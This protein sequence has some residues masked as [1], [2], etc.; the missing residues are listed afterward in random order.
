MGGGT[1]SQRSVNSEESELK[2]TG[3]A[4][5]PYQIGSAAALAE[6]RDKVNGGERDADAVLTANIDLSEE[7]GSWTPIGNAQ[8]VSGKTYKGSF[9]GQ[10]HSVKNLYIAGSETAGLFGYIGSSGTVQNLR[11]SGSITNTSNTTTGGGVAAIN[12]G[13]IENC[14]SSVTIIATATGN[15]AVTVGGVVGL[16]AIGSSVTNCCNSSSVSGTGSGSGPIVV[17]GVV[18][19][20]F[21]GSLTV[22][23]YATEGDKVTIEV[24]PD[25][26]YLLDELVVTAGGKDVELTDNHDGTFTFTM[27]SA[28]VK[29]TATFAED[30]DW[31]EPEEPVTDVSDIFLDVA[32]NAWYKDAVQYAYD[33]GLMTGVSDTE[34]APEATTTR[35]ET[36]SILARLEGVTSA[37]AAGFT[38]VTDEWYA[39]AVN[40]AASVG[41][42]NGYE[43]GTFQPNT[44]I[45]REQLAAILMNYAAY[46]GEDVS[47]RADLSS[48]TN[49]PSTWATEAMQWAVAEELITGVT[50]DELQPQS[51]ATRAQVAAILQRFLAE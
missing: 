18:G 13:R 43:D 32:P 25:E 46:K 24:A 34:F 41:V 17:G 7:K 30:P 19:Q 3:T 39:T 6:F 27:P 49:Q 47:A 1:V 35:A 22:D 29:I 20:N 38:D 42:V 5:D 31:T 10:G 2:G 14:C 9:D 28:D 8:T 50:N 48:Y 37:E 36:C 16:N 33:N 45:T 26:A 23:R 44:A 15:N 40:W 21:N 51:S 4:E 12:D 11:V